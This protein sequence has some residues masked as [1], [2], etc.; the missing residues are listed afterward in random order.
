M[1]KSAPT[2]PGTVSVAVEASDEVTLFT[3]AEFVYDHVAKP[4]P[5][6][7]HVHS[8]NNC[9]LHLDHRRDKFDV[10]A[11][12][13]EWR[14]RLNAVLKFFEDGYA[15]STDGEIVRLAPNGMA[16]LVT[17]P[18]PTGTEDTNAAKL[19]N[20]VHTFQLGRS[21]REQRKQAVRDLADILE[22]H[23][24]A[25]VLHLGKETEKDLFNIANNF[26]LRHHRATQKDDYDDAWLTWMFYT[27]LA[28]V[29]IVLGRVAGSEPFAE[30]ALAAVAT[31]PTDDD[32]PF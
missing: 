29:H 26:S 2:C 20:A 24:P 12:R 4:L 28:S 17:T 15:L 6:E 30:P 31:D 19:A 7:G 10:M 21:T 25:V 18:P 1:R 8:W 16:K 3:I 32:L 13:A 27:Y 9:G 22:Y 23:R 11:G 14:D 5:G